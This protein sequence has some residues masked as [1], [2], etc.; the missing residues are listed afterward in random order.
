MY[1]LIVLEGEVQDQRV[2]NAEFSWG[3]F[4]WCV[5]QISSS[6]KDIRNIGLRPILIASFK[7]NCLSEVLGVRTP[8]HELGQKQHNAH[9]PASAHQCLSILHLSPIT[10]STLTTSWSSNMPQ[11]SRSTAGMIYSLVPWPECEGIYW[12]TSEGS[13]R[14]LNQ[15][16]PVFIN[17]IM[18]LCRLFTGKDHKRDSKY[19]MYAKGKTLF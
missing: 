11:F 13:L 7:C 12:G 6:Y 16:H 18:I 3:L 15:S 17:Y 8:I 5:V 4:P 19:K 14:T 2:G 10:Q 9:H 1:F